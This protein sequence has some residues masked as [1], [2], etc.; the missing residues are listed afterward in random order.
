MWAE[1]LAAM[2]RNA[3]PLVVVACA[4]VFLGVKANRGEVHEVKATATH[5]AA[6]ET[7]GAA[8]AATVQAR[9]AAK[10]TKRTTLRRPD[11]T[12]LTSE[13]TRTFVSVRDAS[14]ARAEVSKMEAERESVHVETKD[15]AP[16]PQ[17]WRFTL[18]L[19]VGALP[20]DLSPRLHVDLSRRL[21]GPLWATSTLTPPVLGQPLSLR[22]GAA[23]IF[24]W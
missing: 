2:K 14:A 21:F 1:L 11:G 3:L 24:E 19:D 7:A 23:L 13:R 9:A 5:E 12:T 10:E 15:V 6:A 22:V 16:V 20:L 18:G 4:F 17:A 8:Q